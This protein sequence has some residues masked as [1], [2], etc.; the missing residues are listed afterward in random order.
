M[1][2][3]SCP[4]MQANTEENS[5]FPQ[6]DG[7]NLRFMVNNRVLFWLT[8]C[9]L[10]TMSRASAPFSNAISA[11]SLAVCAAILAYW[12][13]ETLTASPDFAALA[14]AVAGGG[15]LGRLKRSASHPRG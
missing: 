4:A 12:A 10:E 9:I 1:K 14:G 7:A 3:D 8:V 15:L 2:R 5:G 13:I 11:A 6:S